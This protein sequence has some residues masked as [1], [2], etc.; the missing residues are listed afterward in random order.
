VSN[1]D[2][3][4]P[5]VIR[6][7]FGAAP[8]TPIEKWPPDTLRAYQ[9]DALAEQ[10]QH[11]Y[12]NN[13]FYRQKFDAAGVKPGDFGELAD[14]ARFPFTEKDELRGDPWVLLSVP[15]SQVCLTHTSTGTTGGA[16]SYVHYSW[17]DMHERDWAGFAHLL[18]DIRDTDVVINALPYEMSSAG[19]SFQR[20]LQGAAGAAVVPVGKGGFYSEADKTVRVMADLAADVLITTPPYAMVLS[21][22][23]EA[24]SLQPGR[25]IRLRFM[26]ITGEGC[27][28][29]Y[30]RRLEQR[31]QC[32]ALVF[33]GSLECGPIGIEC[34]EQSGCH[35]S[36]GHVYLE[37]IDPK[38][39]KPKPPGEIGEVVC[40]T[41]LRKAS[42][43]VRYRTQDL[44]FVD[45][46]PC[47][48][49]VTF[50]KLHIRG[51]IA[52]QV[53]AQ[54]SAGTAQAS[55]APVSPY[56]IEEVLFSQ[57]EMGG[58]YQIY[59]TDSGLR[60]EAE[61]AAGAKGERASNTI[62]EQLKQR[63]IT[64]ELAWVDHIPRTGGKTRRVRP[65]AERQRVMS[66]SCIV[67]MAL[68]R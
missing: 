44:A 14:A 10:L 8:E 16:W 62:V 49:G 50:P 65:I 1:R 56:L 26:W 31:W 18:M 67:R 34:R 9:R 3:E 6:R 55:A 25:D 45:P 32:P 68:G 39:G 5:A 7:Y 38:T 66:E 60:I 64:A 12:A 2:F 40:T 37:I 63:G 57:L 28:P 48:C 21:E 58:N 13:A 19:Q 52:D 27:S 33:Y 23:A 53:A 20:S 59:T 30:R 4:L 46:A 41:L 35:V 22:V 47:P 61:L 24:L 17:K 11:V 29:A 36:G 43:L 15:K 54:A 51:R 42:P